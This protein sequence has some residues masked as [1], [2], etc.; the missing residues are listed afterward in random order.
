MEV[1]VP[2]HPVTT[3]RQFFTHLAIVSVGLL[4]ALS[5]ESLVEWRH[6]RALVREARENVRREISENRA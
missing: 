6:H 2:D 5:L 1:H 3:W 4:I